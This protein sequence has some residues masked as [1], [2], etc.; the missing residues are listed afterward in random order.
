MFG[1][2]RKV[3]DP[4]SKTASRYL[5]SNLRGPSE[6]DLKN[7]HLTRYKFVGSIFYFYTKSRRDLEPGDEVL[8][9]C[10]LASGIFK[11]LRSISLFPLFRANTR[12]LGMLSSSDEVY[13]DS[14]S[15]NYILLSVTYNF[16]LA[17]WAKIERND[18]KQ[19]CDQ[20]SLVDW[21]YTCDQIESV[22][23]YARIVWASLLSSIFCCQVWLLAQPY[24]PNV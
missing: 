19:L 22:K 15:L 16:G 8:K 23:Q 20:T 2:K 7:R 11:Q 4:S 1:G 21:S 13:D 3:L 5:P 6:K 12:R 24:F 17:K 14:I 10:M 9:S 18:G